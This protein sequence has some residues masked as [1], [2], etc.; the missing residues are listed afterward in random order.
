MCLQTYLTSVDKIITRRYIDQIT[1]K[2]IGA[3]I[4]VHKNVGPG[5]LESIY[6]RCL[7]KEFDLQKIDYL[8]E[9]PVTVSY[10][11]MELDAEL[12]CDFVVENLIVIEIKATQDI[13]PVY[14]AQL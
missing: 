2:V 11:G 4:E 8:S 14:E 6:H 1:Y 12:R 7:K 9:L 10:K 5:L 3:A 13:N